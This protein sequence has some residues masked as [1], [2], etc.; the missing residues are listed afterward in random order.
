[1][2]EVRVTDILMLPSYKGNGD[3]V[4]ATTAHTV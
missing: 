4:K 3:C 1:M 2:K